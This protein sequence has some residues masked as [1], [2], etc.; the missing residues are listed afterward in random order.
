VQAEDNVN[1]IVM[2]PRWRFV[3]D[4]VG[5]VVLGRCGTRFGVQESMHWGSKLRKCNRRGGRGLCCVGGGEPCS[6]GLWL[7]QA[8]SLCHS[9]THARRHCVSACCRRCRLPRMPPL[10]TRRV[11]LVRSKSLV[12]LSDVLGQNHHAGRTFDLICF[13]YWKQ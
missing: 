1:V 2:L 9:F 11:R 8:P 4:L 6:V 13:Y 7:A 12:L 10:C 5:R 3:H